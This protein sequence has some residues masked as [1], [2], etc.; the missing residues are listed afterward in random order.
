MCKHVHL[1][2]MIASSRNVDINLERQIQAGTIFNEGQYFYDEENKQVEIVSKSGLVSVVNIDSYTCSCFASS[3]NITCTCITVAKM[4]VPPSDVPPSELH[5]HFNNEIEE[6]KMAEKSTDILIQR[7]IDEI[8][9]LV[10]SE[11]FK[12]VTELKKKNVLQALGRAY[13]ICR[14]NSYC[15]KTKK[16]KIQP[17]FPNRKSKL[18]RNDHDYPSTT[19]HVL[20]K[21]GRTLNE[22]GSFKMASRNKGCTRKPFQ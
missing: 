7:K 8:N 3:H 14:L 6:D 5:V 12:M 1:A 19:K 11:Q 4:V 2:Q 16:R 13:N 9:V 21:K 15:K 20:N 10:N 18:P 22:D 17:L